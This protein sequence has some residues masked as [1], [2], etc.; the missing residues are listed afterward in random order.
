MAAGIVFSMAF[1]KDIVCVLTYLLAFNPIFKGAFTWD[2]WLQQHDAT[3]MPTPIVDQALT[4]Q[5]FGQM[6]S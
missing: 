4:T 5:I 2:N 6:V 3:G 1:M